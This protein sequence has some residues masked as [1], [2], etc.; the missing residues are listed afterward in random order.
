[1]S[2]AGET[3]ED[4]KKIVNIACRLM[5]GQVLAGKL[6]PDDP[7]ALKKAAIQAGKDARQAYYAALEFI[8]G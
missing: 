5:E 1:M 6:N 2:R 3:E 7:E 8:C 4:R